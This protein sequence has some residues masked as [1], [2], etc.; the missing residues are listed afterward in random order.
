MLEFI[1]NGKKIC[2][3]IPLGLTLLDFIRKEERLKGTKS[4]CREG[5]CGSCTVLMGTLCGVNISYKSVTSCITPVGNA[6]GKHVVTV[7]GINLSGTSPIQQALI[8]AAAVQC[9]YCTPG[10]VMS[11]T[12][13]IISQ[14]HYSFESAK[15]AIAGNICRCTG[16]KSIEKAIALILEKINQVDKNNRLT[17]LVDN[18]YLPKYFEGIKMQLE[19]IKNPE[20]KKIFKPIIGGGTDLYVQKPEEMFKADPFLVSDFP[21][22]N[23]IERDGD[24]FTLGAACKISDLMHHQGLEERLLHIKKHL[25]LIASE[26]VRNLATLAGN[27]VNASPIGDL[28]IMFLALDATVELLSI[29]NEPRTLKLSHFFIDYKKTELAENEIIKN[30]SFVLPAGEFHFNFEKVSKRK[31]LDI[32]S[33]NSSILIQLENE[34]IS[35]VHLSMGGVAP[36]PLY[37]A[38][39]CRWMLGKDL[40]ILM[41]KGAA[42]IINDEIAPISDVRGSADYK[43]LLARQ[44][45]YAHFIELFPEKFDLEK[46][47]IAEYS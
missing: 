12:G 11:L 46:L 21:L 29:T 23:K 31:Y 26:P 34:K 30:I 15:E 5:D 40:N 19:S 6:Q 41:I 24:K 20:V 4:A 18:N 22:L 25:R 1:L 27:L 47:L 7:E 32:A 45:F 39:T 9:G 43:R 42:K 2:A 10:I 14:N 3:D 33:V 35:N 36:I 28:S 13:Y 44:L 38:E 17:W 37:L 16:Y 8:D